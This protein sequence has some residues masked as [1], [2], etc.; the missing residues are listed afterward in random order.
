MRAGNKPSFPVTRLTIGEPG[1]LA[2]HLDPTALAPLHRPSVRQV[3]EQKHVHVAEPGGSF[4]PAETLRQLLQPCI[5]E[6]VGRKQPID[7][8]EAIHPCSR[9]GLRLCC[10]LRYYSKRQGL[11]TV[12]LSSS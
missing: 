5:A 7:D 8:I 10:A 12:G 4:Q 6:H 9:L 3:I 1:W 2:E 11:A